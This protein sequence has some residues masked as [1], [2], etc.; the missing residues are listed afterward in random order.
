MNDRSPTKIDSAREMWYFLML[1]GLTI[2]SLRNSS[3]PYPPINFV[4]VLQTV[5]GRR[6]SLFFRRKKPMPLDAADLKITDCLLEQAAHR[7]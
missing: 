7:W 4:V 6:E 5:A 2:S 3:L 1:R